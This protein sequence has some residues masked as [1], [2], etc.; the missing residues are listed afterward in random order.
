V[1]SFDNSRKHNKEIAMATTAENH[2]ETSYSSW[3]EVVPSYDANPV[4][5]PA[6]RALISIGSIVK[7]K[8]G[9]IVRVL[10]ISG[11]LTNPG[12]LHVHG[13]RFVLLTSS[14]PLGAQISPFIRSIRD[15]QE[16]AETKSKEVFLVSDIADI[17]FVF[18]KETIE[19]QGLCLY[20]MLNAYFIRFR[21]EA[22]GT[23]FEIPAESVF[24][25]SDFSH[26]SPSCFSKRIWLG[27]LSLQTMFRTILSR[28]A[29]S[30]G[31][32]TTY[33]VKFPFSRE[34]W[35]YLLFR[36]YNVADVATVKL[37][38]IRVGVVPGMNTYTV[39]FFPEGQSISLTSEEHLSCVQGLL[40]STILF[41]SRHRRPKIG[42]CRTPATNNHY[43]VITHESHD[44][45]SSE[46]KLSL[47]DTNLHVQV[48]YVLYQYCSDE[49]G[50]P[51]NCP[52]SSLFKLF[53]HF[54]PGVGVAS[55]QQVDMEQNVQAPPSPSRHWQEA[56]A[57]GAMFENDDG[58]V[59]V[60][61]DV[62][63][64]NSE[65]ICHDFNHHEVVIV[66]TDFEHVA[67][68]IDLYNSIE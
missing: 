65:I 55:N 32:H 35:D 16:V 8:D 40:G 62:N 42:Q 68:M 67:S 27:I 18:S 14:P 28:G 47:D 48:S 39:R 22:N 19:E 3:N 49:A 30:Q 45:P 61:R 23:M 46:I 10:S 34:T 2:D 9:R 4:H 50:N 31:M 7:L 20:G 52:S 58:V 37:R 15:K 59:Y 51:I 26:S 53:T 5:V 54:R 44:Y 1:I 57:V 64:P 25:S 17:V 38:Q 43:N 66:M 41:G 60:V 29:S 56:V 11:S 13:N 24:F 36:F 12:D 21:M 33:K 63:Y 6:L